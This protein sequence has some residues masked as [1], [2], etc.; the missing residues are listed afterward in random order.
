M[1]G[2]SMRFCLVDPN[3]LRLGRLLCTS[4]GRKSALRLRLAEQKKPGSGIDS[5]SLPACPILPGHRTGQL[6]WV[7]VKIRG[8]FPL[9]YPSQRS[10]L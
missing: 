2:P 4:A 3:L 7:C 10:E 1:P 6:L 5:N 9:G 8:Q